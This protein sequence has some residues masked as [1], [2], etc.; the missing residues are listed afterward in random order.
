MGFKRF[1]LKSSFGGGLIQGH[2]VDALAKKAKTG[3][4]FREC[5]GESVKET[6]TEDNPVTSHVSIVR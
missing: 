4:T 2:I 5:L 1:L 3:K 6:F